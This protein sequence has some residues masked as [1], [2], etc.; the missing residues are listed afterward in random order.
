MNA[1]HP[2][3]SYR[4]ASIGLL[5][6]LIQA[7]IVVLLLLAVA[8]SLVT[9]NGALGAIAALS[10]LLI[11]V[12]TMFLGTIGKLLCLIAPSSRLGR[13]CVA[14]CLIGDFLGL[15]VKPL[16]PP[17]YVGIGIACASQCLFML[18]LIVL[19]RVVER[20]DI[21]RIVLASYIMLMV[22]AVAIFVIRYVRNADLAPFVC[23]IVAFGTG[24][25]GVLMYLRAMVFLCKATRQALPV[26]TERPDAQVDGVIAVAVD[27]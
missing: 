1:T 9:G 27:E 2:V 4:L 25:Y 21:R 6:L 20:P 10:T 3:R 17:P 8:V 16:D 15:G 13:I 19:A 18:Y 5:L 26:T 7:A 11:I 14:L 22:A 24:L 12:P 23:A